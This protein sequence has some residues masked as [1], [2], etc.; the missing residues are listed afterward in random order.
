[1]TIYHGV[2]ETLKNL[3]RPMILAALC[4][5]VCPWWGLLP[6]SSIA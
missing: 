5:S 6:G 4:V 3:D 1:M 2:T